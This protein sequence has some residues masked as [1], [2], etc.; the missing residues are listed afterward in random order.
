MTHSG[1]YSQDVWSQDADLSLRGSVVEFKC[2]NSRAFQWESCAQGQIGGR[3][4]CTLKRLLYLP[5]VNEEG[6]AE[7]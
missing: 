4:G 6:P 1:S 3:V 5:V 7:A 2:W